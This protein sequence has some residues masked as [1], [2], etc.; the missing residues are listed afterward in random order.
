MGRDGQQASGHL[1]LL[2]GG[3]ERASEPFVLGRRQTAACPVRVMVKQTNKRPSGRTSAQPCMPS[4]SLP[5]T[6]TLPSPRH[7]Y[8]TPARSGIQPRPL[9][10]CF[11]RPHPH[12]NTT[13]IAGLR[14]RTLQTRRPSSRPIS[15]E[16]AALGSP[17]PCH[18]IISAPIATLSAP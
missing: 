15:R 13:V 12:P 14:Q 3:H 8:V 18:P 11:F 4:M 17:S 10:L 5:V 2:P 1:A 7:P 6:H 16:P 9:P